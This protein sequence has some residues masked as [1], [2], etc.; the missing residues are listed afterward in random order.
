MKHFPQVD[1]ALFDNEH[2]KFLHNFN[3]MTDLIYALDCEGEELPARR[4]II[5]LLAATQLFL[6]ATTL[7]KEFSDIRNKSRTPDMFKTV[8]ETISNEM[9]IA[10]L[11]LNKYAVESKS[12]QIIKS[13]VNYCYKAILIRLI[14][15]KQSNDPFYAEYWQ[16]S[17]LQQQIR[18]RNQAKEEG[19]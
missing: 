3:E 16:Q 9:N 7:E 15:L 6:T 19:R 1:V 17:S 10:E 14:A 12:H 13:V 5:R 18:A 4:D 2:K 11:A 8:L